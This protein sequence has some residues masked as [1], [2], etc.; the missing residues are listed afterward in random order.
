MNLVAEVDF[1]DREKPK[2]S[3][4]GP[5]LCV[6]MGENNRKIARCGGTYL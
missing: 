4:I 3:Q 2:Q 1:I 5:S 6:K